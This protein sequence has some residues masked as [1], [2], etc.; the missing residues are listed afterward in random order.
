MVLASRGLC[1]IY[2]HTTNPT[3]YNALSLSAALGLVQLEDPVSGGMGIVSDLEYMQFHPTGTALCMPNEHRFLLIEALQEEGAI[4]REM[5]G[6]A[7]ALD[8]HPNAE[9]VPRDI[10]ACAVYEECRKSRHRGG[11]GVGDGGGDIQHNAYLDIMHCNLLWLVGRFPGVHVH[12]V[13]HMLPLDL[14]QGRQT[15]HARGALHLQRHD[16]RPQ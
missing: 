5:H 15:H 1:G 3:G 8:Y 16:D 4:L 9:L 2:K 7:F 12:L 6:R 14:N 11:A 10:V 13:S